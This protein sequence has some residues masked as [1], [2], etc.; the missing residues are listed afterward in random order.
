[1][2]L[3]LEKVPRLATGPS[4]MWKSMVKLGRDRGGPTKFP[5]TKL[6]DMGPLLGDFIFGGPLLVPESAK[7]AA[8]QMRKSM[9]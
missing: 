5:T 3:C 8:P 2:V 1:M 6:R 4:K 9:S 7:G